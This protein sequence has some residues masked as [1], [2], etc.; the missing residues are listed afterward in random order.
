MLRHTLIL[1]AFVFGCGLTAQDFPTVTVVCQ[2]GPFTLA[3]PLTDGMTYTYQWE[4]SFDGGSSWSATGIDAPELTVSSPN[5]GISYRLAYAPD[6]TC[7]SDVSCRSLTSATALVVSIPSFSQGRS[8]CG[9]DTLF[10]GNTAL[11]T[12]GNHETTLQTA[13]GNCDSI[14]STFL[15]ILPAYNDR[16]FVDLCPGESFR[17]QSIGADTV[18]TQSFTAS[19]GCDS[20]ATYEISVAFASQPII[21]G[22]DRICAGETASL[23][24]AGAF[25]TYAWSTGNDGDDAPVTS[26]GNYTLTLTDFN[27]CQLE[28]SHQMAVTE[29]NVSDAITTPPACPGGNSGAISVLA[30]GDTDLLYSIDGGESFQP[31]S[32]FT[33][34]AAGAYAL[35]VEN[36]E[37]C[38][39]SSSTNVDD[40]PGLNIFGS[41]LSEQT[42]ERGDSVFADFTADFEVTEWRWNNQAFTTCNDCPATVLIPMVDTRFIIEAI[43]PGGCSVVDSFLI[44]V[45]DKQ[46]Y[47]APT[48]FSPN[49]DNQND[50]WRLFA[51]PRVEA[52][53]SLQVADRWGGIR[54]QQ[55]TDLPPAEA[56]W[57]GN[58]QGSGQ[59]L[60]PGTYVWSASL[61]YADGSSR[62]VRGQI[63]LMR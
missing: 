55:T 34:L 31:D 45:K 9:G 11:T 49:G 50:V 46:R 14:V 10:V 61:R 26:A 48:A 2:N 42:I 35:V 1:L 3:S 4:R 43:A 17:G 7:L 12:G 63:T 20:I 40:A 33:D 21:S 47:Y 19:S 53:T 29:L 13:D 54:Y 24:V 57:D 38:R 51:G 58:E 22:P 52:V 23:E 56:G 15:Q 59:P 62:A 18:I 41:L 32:D 36:I 27:G 8:I 37:G 44:N 39:A 16:F 28:L 25:A 60:P 30:A 6:V 5:S